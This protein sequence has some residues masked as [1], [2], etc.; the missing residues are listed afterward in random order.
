[1]TEPTGEVNKVTNA[2]WEK[3]VEATELSPR[4]FFFKYGDEGTKTKMLLYSLAH[5]LTPILLEVETLR[6]KVAELEKGLL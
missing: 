3:F 2:L 1:M 6:Q 4:G 5:V